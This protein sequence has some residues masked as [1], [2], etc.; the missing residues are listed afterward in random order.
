[1]KQLFHLKN[2]DIKATGNHTILLEIGEDYCCTAFCG[3]DKTI[4]ELHYYTFDAIDFKESIKQLLDKLQTSEAVNSKLFICAAFPQALL[5]PIKLYKEETESEL[6]N[7]L[8]D[9]NNSNILKD[10]IEAWQI[11]NVYAV[12]HFLHQAISN[13]FASADFI[14]AYTVLLKTPNDI[15]A[16]NQI[17]IH[18]TTTTFRVKVLKN[19]HLQLMQTFTYSAPLDAVYVLL[20]ICTELQLQ[21]SEVHIILSGLV[22]EN[23][24]LYKEL[25]QYFLNIRFANASDSLAE[26]NN[27]PSHFF[28]SLHNF[29]ACVL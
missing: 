10:E 14:H 5:T 23:S 8:Y 15:T 18:F 3:D 17:A 28:T 19:K 9:V 7:T 4:N 16:E 24:A 25:Y 29:S 11:V 1:M 13:S 27:L 20:K 22:E 21:Q 26:Q 2:G 6:L 12:P